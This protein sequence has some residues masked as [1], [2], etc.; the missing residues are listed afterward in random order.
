V[1]RFHYYVQPDGALWK[2]TDGN[3][4]VTHYNTQTEAA[5]VA[6]SAAQRDHQLGYNAQVHIARPTGR[7]RTEWTY[8]NDPAQ[9]P[10]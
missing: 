1:S 5:G 9:F 10:G 8:G 6:R 3:G 7:W 2:V 4:N